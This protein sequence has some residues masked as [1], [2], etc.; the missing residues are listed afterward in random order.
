[1]LP[2]GKMTSIPDRKEQY[3]SV[4]IIRFIILLIVVGVLTVSAA[5]AMGGKTRLTQTFTPA[6]NSPVITK[7]PDPILPRELSSLNARCDMR[8]E[9]SLPIQVYL[10]SGKAHLV[11]P[12][13]RVHYLIDSSTAWKWKEASAS[14]RVW[15]NPSR[16]QIASDI[17]ADI[18]AASGQTEKQ[19]QASLSALTLPQNAMKLFQQYC[20]TSNLSPFPSLPQDMTF[21]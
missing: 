21:E 5:L 2:F 3:L 20:T 10:S 17:L 14:G 11:I 12:A 15:Q 19:Q 4:Q 18:R 16:E 1:M 9:A 13:T 7:A 6:N 8:S